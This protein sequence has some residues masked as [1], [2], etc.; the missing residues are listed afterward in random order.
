MARVWAATRTYLEKSGFTNTSCGHRRLPIKPGMAERMPNFLATSARI[1]LGLGPDRSA[2]IT[3]W[4][5]SPGS[6]CKQAKQRLSFAESC[7]VAS[8]SRPQS[9]KVA[10]VAATTCAY[11]EK[12]GFIRNSCWHERH[13]LMHGDDERMPYILPTSSK[14]Q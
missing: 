12:C 6:V 1:T 14:G 8:Q 9:H 5:I 4:C 10:Q 3:A 11:M 2:G 7:E 13:F